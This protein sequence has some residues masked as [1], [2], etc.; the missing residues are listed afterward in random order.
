MT[1][2]WIILLPFLLTDIL[3]P[4]LFAFLVFAAGTDRPI[5][6]SVL[7]LLGHT[8]AYFL[9]GI[10]LALGLEQFMERLTNPKQ[11]DYFIEFFIGA[12]L[13]LVAIPSRRSADKKPDET[14][15]TLTRVEAF[16][17]GASVKFV[18]I[19]FANPYFAAIGQILKADLTA[20]DALL[21]IGVYNVAYALPFA[22]VPAMTV[23]LGENSRPLLA[24]INS[25][26]ER[27]S[28]FI[29]PILLGLIGLALTANAVT[30]LITGAA[31]F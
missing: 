4:V 21:V 28:G 8:A 2:L 25:V 9:A 7:L 26:L 10:L 15:P 27:I 22:A 12:A 18:G 16:I 29:M 23:M 17:V 5:A 11:I 13:L 19:P 31:L 30:Y 24:R 14:Q 3:N 20:L 6:N 1:D